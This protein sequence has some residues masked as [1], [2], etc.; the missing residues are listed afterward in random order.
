MSKLFFGP[1]AAAVL[2]TA[3]LL[4]M[5]AGALA[6]LLA[7]AEIPFQFQA[8]GKLMPPGLYTIEPTSVPGTVQVRGAGGSAVLLTITVPQQRPD[9]AAALV[10]DKTSGTP[11]LAGI[12]YST[13]NSASFLDLR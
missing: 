1:M 3:I 7:R 4:V 11:R 9:G 13:P 12:R 10:F 5:P 6:G 2:A 8:G